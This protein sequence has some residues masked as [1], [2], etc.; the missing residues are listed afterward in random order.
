M[1]KALTAV[2]DPHAGA[3]VSFVGIVRKE[4][5]VR[6]LVYEVYDEMAER[7]LEQMRRKAIGRFGLINAVVIHR[8]GRLKVG[9]RVVIVA[10]S[11]PHRREAFKACE[12]LIS[13]VKKIVPIWKREV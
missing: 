6:A 2:T 8:K 12:W 10:C 7:K 13:E 5:G 1:E 4:K 11:A 3:I 9:E